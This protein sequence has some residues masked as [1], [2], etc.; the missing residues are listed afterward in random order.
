MTTTDPVNGPYTR[1]PSV[2]VSSTTATGLESG[3]RAW[4]RARGVGPKGEGPWSDPGT[5]I[6]P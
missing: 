6:V 4:I 3:K 2:T 5:K 1:L